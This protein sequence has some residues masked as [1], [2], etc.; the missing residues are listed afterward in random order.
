MSA[1]ALSMHLRDLGAAR[2][3]VAVG[4]LAGLPAEE[5]VHGHPGL[6]PLDVPQRH[7]DAADRVVEHGAVPPVRARVEG[8]PGVLDP[9]RGLADQE[10]LQVAVHRGGHE[11]G[12]LGERGAAVAVEAVLVGRHLDHH[13]PQPRGC[14]GDG[15]HVG[16][17]RRGQAAKRFLDLR[18]GPGRPRSQEPRRGAA[19]GQSERL[20]PL[21]APSLRPV[22]V[23]GRDATPGAAP[24]EVRPP[25]GAAGS[26]CG[27]R[28][29]S[30][31]A[32]RSCPAC[33]CSR[34][35]TRS[36]R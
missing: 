23:S 17:L 19:R 26:R 13:E 28:R 18:V 27:R 15:A 25:P 24:R 35:S 7:V 3:P 12:P 20:A 2:V 11:V 34:P 32:A 29:C 33:S 31:P 14:R 21:H 5:L 10:R 16:D 22:P 6:P 4:R 30:G 36:A 8:L 1:R 9:V